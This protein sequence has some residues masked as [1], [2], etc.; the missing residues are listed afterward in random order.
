MKKI[1]SSLLLVVTWPFKFLKKS[2]FDNFVGGLIFG[3]VFSLVV[4]IITV[5]IQ[6]KINKQ[7]ALEGLENEIMINVLQANN[8]IKTNDEASKNNTPINFFYYSPTYSIDFW[9]QSSEPLRY[10]AQLD[11]DI[12]SGIMVLYSS[13]FKNAN[14]Y[15]NRTNNLIDQELPKCFTDNFVYK[16]DDNSCVMLEAT[17]RTSENLAADLVSQYGNEVLSYF[18]PTQDRLNNW[19]LKALMG[20]KSM[21]ILSGE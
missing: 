9:T 17:I 11:Q 2:K 5:Q 10:S 14:G 15:V 4:N 19:F 7:R 21:R 13:I 6:E 12:Q 16:H 3:A 1:V 20:G 8:I 18:H